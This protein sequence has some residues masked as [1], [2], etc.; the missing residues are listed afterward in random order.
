MDVYGMVGERFLTPI[1]VVWIAG[2]RKELNTI[3]S[4]ENVGDFFV[5]VC[6]L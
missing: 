5:V 4:S 1:L 2:D 6:E 3:I